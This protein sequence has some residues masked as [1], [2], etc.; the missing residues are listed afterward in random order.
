MYQAGVKKMLLCAALF[1]LLANSQNTSS[2]LPPVFTDPNRVE[3]IQDAL[4]LITSMYQEY[5]KNNHVPGY[6]FG[7]IVDGRLLAVGQGGYA[8]VAKKTPVNAH[9]M[10]RIAS[11]TKSFTAMAILKLRDAG[12]LKLDDPV[13]HYIPEL[14][15]QKLTEDSPE[16]TI[17][18]L[19]THGAG[20]P[21]DAPWGDRHLQQRDDELIALLKKGISFSTVTGTTYEYS[22]LGFAMLGLIIKKITGMPYQEYIAANIWQPLGMNEATWEFTTVPTP[23][24]AHGYHWEKGHWQEEAL[25]HDGSFGAMGGILTSMDS[26]SRYVALQQTAWPARDEVES[27]PLKRS[28]IREMQQ[29]WRFYAFQVPAKFDAQGCATIRAY[30]Y[31]LSWLRDCRERVYLGHSGGLPGFGSNW[32]MM[33]EYGIAAVF[34]AN[35]TYAAAEAINLKVVNTLLNKAHLKPRQLP[36]SAILQA[37]KEQLIKLLPNWQAA[38]ETGIFAVNFFLDSAEQPL[39]KETQALFA[40]VGKIVAI[41]PLIPESQL[42]GYFIMKGENADLKISFTLSPDKPALIQSYQIEEMEPDSNEVYVA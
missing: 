9:T 41:G 2:Y 24:L 27:G 11:M 18:D 40:K 5:A 26:F 33:P 13:R 34:F 17:R 28:S 10:F 4:P 6:V 20:F 30:G 3:K 39:R 31:G 36:P 15:K 35:S 7:I 21:E 19:L 14:N 23:Q 16:I 29:P 32:V 42:R 12:K 37:R 22:N 8:D 1:P 38:P 25:L